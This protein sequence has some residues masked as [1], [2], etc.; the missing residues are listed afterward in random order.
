MK[1]QKPADHYFRGDAC[2][3]TGDTQQ[4]AGSLFYVYELIEGHRKGEQIVSQKA[5]GQF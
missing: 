4:I 1:E 3:W 5:P 2:K